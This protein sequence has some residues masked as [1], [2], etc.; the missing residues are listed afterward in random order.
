M[1]KKNT[2]FS[3]SS[4]AETRNMDTINEKTGNFY[5][6]LAII[7]KRANQLNQEIK[8]ELHAKLNEFA[9]TSDNLE[10]VFENREQIEISK[11][12]ERLPNPAV[13]ALDEFMNDEIYHRNKEDEDEANV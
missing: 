13:M 5:K 9:T 12:Y 10:E 4:F 1:L 8:E 3:I 7:S 11:Y 2:E 6:S